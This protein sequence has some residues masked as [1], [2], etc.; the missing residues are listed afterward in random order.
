[1][2]FVFGVLVGALAAWLLID[3][4]HK[5]KPSGSFIFDMANPEEEPCRLEM[6]DSISELYHKKYVVLQV[7]VLEDSQD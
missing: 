5:P 7:K 4:L 6:D 3:V 1:M 2:D